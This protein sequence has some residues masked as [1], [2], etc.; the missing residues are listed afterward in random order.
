VEAE[1]ARECG[2]CAGER[3]H[4]CLNPNPCVIGR[5]SIGANASLRVCSWWGGGCGSTP[6]SSCPAIGGTSSARVW[7]DFTQ[8][9]KASSL[10]R[11]GS[12]RLFQFPSAAGW[13]H[14]GLWLGT[15]SGI[16]VLPGRTDRGERA[17]PR[18]L[19]SL[20]MV[21]GAGGRSAVRTHLLRSTQ[22]RGRP[23]GHVA[24]HDPASVARRL[25][26]CARSHVVAKRFFEFLPFAAQML[27]AALVLG[28]G[29]WRRKRRA[30]VAEGL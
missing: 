14:R 7:A 24:W 25:V 1:A 9:G 4:P 6:G 8:A 13:N 29:W 30:A 3:T 12:N 16:P 27:L 11:P 23:N 18:S 19:P 28:I 20:A 21:V 22:S 2:G 10:S 15:F 17:L 26:V 5:R